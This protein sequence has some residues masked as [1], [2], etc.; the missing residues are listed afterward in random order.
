MELAGDARCAGLVATSERRLPT[1]A[2]GKGGPLRGSTGIRT[3]TYHFV[4]IRSLQN[5]KI[6]S[7]FD[8]LIAVYT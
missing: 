1:R 7:G 4:R 5:S 3:L 2:G 8:K 6:V